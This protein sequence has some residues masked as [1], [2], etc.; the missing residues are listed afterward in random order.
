M[1]KQKIVSDKAKNYFSLDSL[2]A[3]DFIFRR[4]FSD[5]SFMEKSLVQ[6]LLLE[7]QHIHASRRTWTSPFTP[8]PSRNCNSTQLSKGKEAPNK[9]EKNSTATIPLPTVTRSLCL[10]RLYKRIPWLQLDIE[11]TNHARHI[12][13]TVLQQINVCPARRG[14]ILCE[15]SYEH[16]MCVFHADLLAPPVIGKA[17]SFCKKGIWLCFI[18]HRLKKIKK[19]VVMY[20]KKNVVRNTRVDLN[21]GVPVWG[22]SK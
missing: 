15:G 11:S 8:Y 4:S 6:D 13:L 1:K 2:W 22:H 14:S 20:I 16:R 5:L 3:Y 21:K 12:E 18:D 9:G 10:Q 7:H 19:G 17:F